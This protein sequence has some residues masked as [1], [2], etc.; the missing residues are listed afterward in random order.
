MHQRSVRFI[1][2]AVPWVQPRRIFALLVIFAV[3]FYAATALA[4]PPTMPLP[5]GASNDEDLLAQFWGWGNYALEILLILIGA[6]IFVVVTWSVVANFIEISR[7][8][9]SFLTAVPRLGVGLFVLAITGVL[10]TIAWNVLQNTT[11]TP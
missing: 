8:G 5:T 2:P 3:A 7:T 1:D 6:A 9:G 10:L 11:L 4:Q